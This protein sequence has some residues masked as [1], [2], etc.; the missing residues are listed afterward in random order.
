MTSLLAQTLVEPGLPPPLCGEFDDLLSELLPVDDD[1]MCLLSFATSSDVVRVE[2]SP[3]RPVS[4]G[5]GWDTTPSVWPQLLAPAEVEG[6]ALTVWEA[7]ACH[8]P[9]FASP[10]NRSTNLSSRTDGLGGEA[11]AAPRN[12]T[13]AAN[14]FPAGN[15]FPVGS[16]VSLQATVVCNGTGAQHGGAPSSS[17]NGGTTTGSP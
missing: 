16:S 10:D 14:S 12:N 15:S 5:R 4:G 11:A 8:L 3:L 7:S 1:Q 17:S 13:G 6:E 2:D 9:A